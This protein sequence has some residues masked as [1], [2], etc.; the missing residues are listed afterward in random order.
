MTVAHRVSSYKKTGALLLWEPT[1]TRG[2]KAPCGDADGAVPRYSVPASRKSSACG[3]PLVLL[4]VAVLSD[5]LSRPFKVL[6]KALPLA[7]CGWLLRDRTST[8][9]NSSH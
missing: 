3:W 2:P 7:A 5:A 1:R 8:R 4:K 6:L 9:L